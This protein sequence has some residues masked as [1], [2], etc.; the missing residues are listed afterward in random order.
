MTRCYWASRTARGKNKYFWEEL[1]NNRLRQGWGYHESQDLRKVTALNVKNQNPVQRKTFRQRHMLGGEGGW[2]DGDIILVPNMPKKGMFALVEII[3]PY[4]FEI[5]PDQQDFG[6]IREVKLLTPH[7]VANTSK[8]VHS[9]IRSTLRNAGRTWKIHDCNDAIEHIIKRAE[10]DELKIHST[11]IQ[12]TASVL[13][14]AFNAASETLQSEFTEGLHGALGKAEWEG[15]IA[16]ALCTYF[17]TGRVKRTGGPNEQGA[18][19]VIELPNPF[20]EDAAWIIVIQV[21]DYNDKVG[22]GVIGQ[23]RQAINAYGEADG[24]PRQ[25][26]QAVLAST[27]AEPSHDLM[28]SMSKLEEETGVPVLAIHGKELMDLVLRGILHVDTE[29]AIRI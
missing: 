25:V 5:A 27:N 15:V 17:P 6:H 8:F 11:N 26:I 24:R 29:Q 13:E 19:V 21:K 16:K 1:K 4:R 7:G 22:E 2:Q 10:D 3:G 20:S 12:R 9:D 28:H 14:K 23:L 18:D